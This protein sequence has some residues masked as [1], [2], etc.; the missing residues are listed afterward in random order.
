MRKKIIIGIP[1]SPGTGHPSNA[2]YIYDGLRRNPDYTVHIFPIGIDDSPQSALKKVFKDGFDTAAEDDYDLLI[3]PGIDQ[4]API[5]PAVPK[6][7][8]QVMHLP[9][10]FCAHL[11][12]NPFVGKQDLSS[13][14]PSTLPFLPVTEC[15]HAVV[16]SDYRGLKEQVFPKQDKANVHFIVT[17]FGLEDYTR[18]QGAFNDYEEYVIILNFN[19]K[20]EISETNERVK[21]LKLDRVSQAEFEECLRVCTTIYPAITDGANTVGTIQSLELPCY[22]MAFK[23]VL[24]KEGTFLNINQDFK[25]ELFKNLKSRTTNATQFTEVKSKTLAYY[26]VGK[27]LRAKGR[28]SVITDLVK[29]ALGT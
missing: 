5:A 28:L 19:K 9:P 13:A 8:K 12:V 25:M 24:M 22:D 15:S 26:S 27:E 6:R 14:L 16:G 7:F 1:V 3:W 23:R 10:P 18:L 11:C 4:R 17:Y 20:I 29:K 21:S 2:K